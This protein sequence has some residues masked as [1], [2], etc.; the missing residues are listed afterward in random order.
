MKTRL[1]KFFLG[2][3]LA[4]LVP[5]GW[6]ALLI[7]GPLGKRVF[8]FARRRWITRQA[9]ATRRLAPGAR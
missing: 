5:G 6:L 1:F 3:R 4:R 7:T 2:K 9:R 8:R